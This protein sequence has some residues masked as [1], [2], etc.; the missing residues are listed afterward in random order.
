MQSSCL[1][2]PLGC[3]STLSK[4]LSLA[5]VSDWNCGDVVQAAR[6]RIGTMLN[7]EDKIDGLEH[8]EVKVFK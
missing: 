3:S 8:V 1:E 6:A 2:H 7:E 4:T 5:G